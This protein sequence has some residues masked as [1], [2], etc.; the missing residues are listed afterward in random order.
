MELLLKIGGRLLNRYVL[1]AALLLV[2]VLGY[3][4]VA[5]LNA[6]GKEELLYKVQEYLPIVMFLTLA[7]LLFSG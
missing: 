2:L 6:E 5:G 3:T 1:L 7:F 4:Y